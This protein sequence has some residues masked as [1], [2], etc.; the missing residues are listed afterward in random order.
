MVGSFLL[1]EQPAPVVHRT[2]W[3][4]IMQGVAK[5]PFSRTG[6]CCLVAKSCL[7]PLRPHG[8]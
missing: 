1:E 2:T 6:N 4:I 3:A 8:L 5:M 7:T